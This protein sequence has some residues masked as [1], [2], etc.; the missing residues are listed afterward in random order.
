MKIFRIINLQGQGCWCWAQDQ[1]DALKR[2]GGPVKDVIDQTSL[3]NDPMHHWY[4][5]TAR[6]MK[7]NATGFACW[8][9]PNRNAL[10]VIM[11]IAAGEPSDDREAESGWQINGVDYPNVPETA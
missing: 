2:W 3:F 8:R 11:A 10:S 1:Q 9:M 7:A 4:A 6:A 5:S